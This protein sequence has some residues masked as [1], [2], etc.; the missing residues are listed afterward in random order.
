M[1]HTTSASAT[2]TSTVESPPTSGSGRVPQPAR[3]VSSPQA[4]QHATKQATSNA[5]P[6]AE[7]APNFSA[8]DSRGPPGAAPSSPDIPSRRA[9][10]A[11]AAKGSAQLNVQAA[12]RS[13]RSP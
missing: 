3:R 1:N 6:A 4:N 9:S 12:Q 11:V 5:S 8:P 2:P 13:G 10:R 7:P